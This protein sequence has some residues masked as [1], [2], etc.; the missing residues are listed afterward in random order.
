M[1]NKKILKNQEVK[2]C[3]IR[4]ATNEFYFDEQGNINDD[5]INYYSELAKNEVG[6]IISGHAF[7]AQQ[8]RA[9]VLQLNPHT[10]ENKQRLKEV[11]EIV[12]ENGA[13]ILM[14][15]AHAGSKSNT[16][17]TKQQVVGPNQEDNCKQIDDQDRLSIINA[18]CE[19]AKVAYETGYDGV[20]VH[21]AHGYLLSSFINRETNRREDHYGGSIENRSRFPLEVIKAVRKCV[22]DHFI[23]SVKIDANTSTPEEFIQFGKYLEEAGVDLIEVSGMGFYKL[24]TS[25]EAY[26]LNQCLELKKNINVPIA[27]VG[28]IHNKECAQHCL[29]EGV[30]YISISRSLISE[31]DL[32]SKWKN[33]GVTTSRCIRCTKCFNLGTRKTCVFN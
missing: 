18:F 13:K 26:W 1:F 16:E 10:S 14:Q 19:T 24:P 23:V 4:S 7:V 28:G 11:T 29:N 6:I 33:D 32:L 22:P 12:H 2:N 30:D 17:V 5:Y 8:G 20:Q 15:I 25:T 3:F 9:S 27:I 21:C 31:P